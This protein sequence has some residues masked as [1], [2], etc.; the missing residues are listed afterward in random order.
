MSASPLRR[1]LA[2]SVAVITFTRPDAGNAMD[3]AFMDAFHYAVSAITA[4]GTARAILIEAEGRNFCV[5]GDLRDFG[6]ADP[7]GAYM[8]RLAGRLHETLK[9]LAAQ[10]APVIV[11]VQG[12]AAGAGLS[13]VASADIAIA[14]QS[15]NFVMAYSGIGLTA[16]G[17]ATWHLPRKIGLQLTQDMAFTGRRLNAKEAERHGLVARVVDDAVLA[18]EA[19]T[20]AERVAAGP[21]AAF[22]AVRNLLAASTGS[23]LEDHL[24]AEC[25]AIT[26]ARASNDAR[27]GI[28]AFIERR[29][30]HFTG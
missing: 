17:G 26:L 24:D 10:R 18:T 6:G 13:L 8:A 1:S 15:A 30:P 27:E 19:R 25:T 3:M 5:G 16:D 4:D 28:A 21:T 22:A 23:S 14:A 7:D 29:T 12:A 20:L 11:A 9:C 2:G